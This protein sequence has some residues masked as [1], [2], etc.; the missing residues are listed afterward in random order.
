MDEEESYTSNEGAFSPIRFSESHIKYKSPQKTSKV[1]ALANVEPSG[2][3]TVH[4][5]GNKEPS[6]KQTRSVSRGKP[7]AA[8]NN[9]I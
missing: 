4:S 7:P 1:T 8:S 6:F 2:S 5:M 9:L 3:L